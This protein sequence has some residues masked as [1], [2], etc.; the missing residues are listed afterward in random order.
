LIHKEKLFSGMTPLIWSLISSQ[1]V[2]IAASGIKKE[3][4]K[5]QNASTFACLLS[6]PPEAVKGNESGEQVSRSGF[7]DRI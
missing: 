4:M 7:I 2:V 3:S 5:S 1:I 6:N